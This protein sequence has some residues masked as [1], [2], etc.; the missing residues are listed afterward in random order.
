MTARAGRG[1]P[2]GRRRPHRWRGAVALL[3]AFA[4]LAGSGCGGSPTD[5]TPTATPPPT[6][7][8]DPPNLILILTDDLDMLATPELTRIRE[9]IADQGMAFTRAYVSMPVCGP[10]RAS[11]M[12]GQYP[13]NHGVVDNHPPLGGFPAF[14]RHEASTIA[15]WLQSAGYRTS[16]VGKYMNDYP[17]G[18]ADNY[19]PPGWDDWY[20]HL[21]A[22]EDDRFFDYW[23]NDNGV[24]RR[25]GTAQ[26]DYSVDVETARAVAFI[27]DAA[28]RP[29]PLFLYLAPEAPH[30]PADYPL[31]H[32]AAFAYAVAPRVP[33]FNEADVR[34][35]PSPVRQQPLLT[36]DRIDWLDN[37]QRRRL[38]S[39]LAV[40]DMVA[41]VLKALSETGRLDNAYVVFTSD[42]GLLMG[43]HR[44]V[45]K[46][47]AA[48]E[49]SIRIPLM[50]RGPGVRVGSVGQPVQLL[51]LAPT[52]LELAGV[53]A[54]DSL[55]GRSLV[56]FLRG[57]APPSWR[58][59]VIVELNDSHALRTP[60]WLYAE[61]DTEEFE[62]YDMHTDPF[63]VDSL[64]R[65]MDPVL[66]QEL[67][68]RIQVMLSCRGASCRESAGATSLLSP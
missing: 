56:P 15:T 28:G 68:E 30:V 39:L 51:D 10:A 41:G 47:R 46:K 33:S 59:D 13:H 3:V 65:R 48:Y 6:P 25:Y 52:L 40:E 44:L 50:V 58:S 4:G 27:D 21:S 45:H 2:S 36:K 29:E 17:L 43:Q 62:L 9:L 35:K 34:D 32:G 26:E 66:M 1:T 16:L 54:P 63:Q 61:L 31:R 5:S 60:D 11:L 7:A 18:V 38:R 37:L 22:F 55:D 64:H 12:T 23:V 20:G 14:R 49:E 57:E 53:P 19:I 24:V 42:N 8:P 67:S